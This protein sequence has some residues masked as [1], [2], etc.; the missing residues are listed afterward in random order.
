M[1]RVSLSLLLV[2]LPFALVSCKE[3]VGGKCSV[4][5]KEICQEKSTALACHDGKW[6]E[7]KC[8]GPAG[9]VKGNPDSCDQSAADD[10]DVCNL[11][12]DVVCTTDKKAMLRCEGYKWTVAQKC[13][14]A[15]ACAVQ[16]K[17]VK[18]DNSLADLG[19]KCTTDNDYACTSDHKG[20]LVCRGKKFE[21]AGACR[22]PKGC[23]VNGDKIECDESVAQ[24]GELCEHDGAPA[25]STDFKAI[26]VCRD[27]KWK[28]DQPCKRTPCKVVGNTIDCK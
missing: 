7:M 20:S 14:G 28:L 6:E 2:C 11:K 19:D 24:E 27:K 8:K 13:G 3:K 25:C 5:E 23:R 22:G 16:A 9:C 21:S 4:A 17:V 26:L 1:P 12:D 18:C 10:G 15:N